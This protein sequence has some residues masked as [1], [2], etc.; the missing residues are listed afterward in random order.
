MND[1]AEHHC[2]NTDDKPIQK[3]SDYNYYLQNELWGHVKC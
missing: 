3:I 1:E 2:I